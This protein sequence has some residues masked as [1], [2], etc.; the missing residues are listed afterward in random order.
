M[1][2]QTLIVLI[3]VIYLGIHLFAPFDWYLI[4]RLYKKLKR[5]EVNGN[6]GKG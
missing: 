6:F 5:R 3:L 1:D 2:A 4:Y